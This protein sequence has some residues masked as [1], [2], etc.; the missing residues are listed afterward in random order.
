MGFLKFS[1]NPDLERYAVLLD[2]KKYRSVSEEYESFLLDE[3]PDLK[4]PKKYRQNVALL[5]EAGYQIKS[6]QHKLYAG[7]I[8]IN[9][10]EWLAMF[11][12]KVK[13]VADVKAALFDEVNNGRYSKADKVTKGYELKADLRARVTEKLL[14]LTNT[15]EPYKLGE[16][17]DVPDDHNEHHAHD[18]FMQ[19]AESHE[20]SSKHILIPV[21]LQSIDTHIES[22]KLWHSFYKKKGAIP[23]TL[24]TRMD[25]IEKDKRSSPWKGDFE[26][27]DAESDYVSEVRSP[28][29]R[30]VIRLEQDLISLEALRDQARN[31]EHPGYVPHT[32]KQCSTGRIQLI[33]GIPKRRRVG[34]TTCSRLVRDIALHGT[35]QYDI[36]AFNHTVALQIA[37]GNGLK[38]TQLRHYVENKQAVR[39]RLAKRMKG[40]ESLAKQALT[41]IMYGATIPDPGIAH[42]FERRASLEKG[43]STPFDLVNLLGAQRYKL[44]VTDKFVGELIEE[45]RTI[46][47]FMIDEARPTGSDTT[48]TNE[49]GIVSNWPTKRSHERKV[50]ANLFQGIE[51][52]AI[53]AAAQSMKSVSFTLSDCVFTQAIEDKAMA[54]HAI[55]KVTGFRL[56]LDYEGVKVS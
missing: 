14:R 4:V 20:L 22:I 29:E 23:D 40:P 36:V 17:C 32:A 39:E 52:A 16:H 30:V 13:R 21:N 41:G 28:E 18:E 47:A 2:E 37:L 11:G 6:R 1:T 43:S 51:V 26:V 42:E 9:A 35:H 15:N 34:V 49:A 25:E 54:E 56:L 12:H 19:E 5:I 55:E 46:F 10:Y 24:T 53:N 38:C 50:V 7:A 27:W 3:L 44:F 48:Y 31:P 33:G 8:T 45:L